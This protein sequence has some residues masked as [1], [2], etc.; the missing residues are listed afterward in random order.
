MGLLQKLF[1]KP[2]SKQEIGE[3]LA[4]VGKNQIGTLFTA[5]MVEAFATEKGKRA[6]A[7]GKEILTR[8]KRLFQGCQKNQDIL[9]R[10]DSICDRW[11]N[12]SDA[13]HALLSD[14]VKA[15]RSIQ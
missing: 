14:L 4:K 8:H 2:L 3:Y 12:V 13:E 7:K 9:S 15:H 1:S 6:A 11:P 5:V 10:L